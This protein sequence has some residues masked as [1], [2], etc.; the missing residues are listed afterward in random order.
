M[1]H[2]H[3]V[4]AR[5]WGKLLLG[6]PKAPP[7]AGGST[8]IH[9]H[10][11]GKIVKRPSMRKMGVELGGLGGEGACGN[12]G[13]IKFQDQAFTQLVLSEDKKELIRAVARNA[14]GGTRWD[15]DELEEDEEDSDD[16]DSIQMDVV[17]N[18][19]GASI[20]LLQGPAGTGKTLTAGM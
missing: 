17:A 18:K 9:E 1:L 6:M 12:C 16:D 3:N 20:F 10:G 8:S 2:Y 5:V 4:L 7:A 15:E 13:Y 14:G 19:G 11:P